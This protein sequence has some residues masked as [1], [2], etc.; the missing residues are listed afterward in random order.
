MHLSISLRI[1]GVLLMIFSVAMLPSLLLALYDQDGSARPFGLAFG[2]NILAG[3]AI[4]LPFR[5]AD[6]DLRI[7]DGFLVT[8]LFWIVLGC[9]GAIPFYTSDALQLSL[10]GAVF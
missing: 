7:R 2:I 10:A 9:F 4:W 6:R 5:D 8:A 3:L 1:T